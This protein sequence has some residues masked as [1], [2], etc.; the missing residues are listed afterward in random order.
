MFRSETSDNMNRKGREVAKHSVFTMF[1]GSGGSTSRLAK[2]AG[3]ETSRQMRNEKLHAVVAFQMCFAPQRRALFQH[4][5]FQKSSETDGVLTLFSEAH[6]EAKSVK[7]L[8]VRS[9]FSS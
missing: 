9:T 4:L 1:C 8:Q 6:L 2:A 5:N 3:A 7:T